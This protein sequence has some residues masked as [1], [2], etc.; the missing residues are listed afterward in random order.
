MLVPVFVGAPRQGKRE[1][2]PAPIGKRFHFARQ[3]AINNVLSIIREEA[4]NLGRLCDQPLVPPPL[5]ANLS[6]PQIYINASDI[7]G[8]PRGTKP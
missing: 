3:R 7:S 5:E 2:K 8:R 6:P 1:K 4:A